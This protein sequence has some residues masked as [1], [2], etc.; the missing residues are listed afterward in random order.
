MFTP[1]FIYA[2]NSRP[3]ERAGVTCYIGLGSNLGRR[4]KNIELALNCLR[5]TGGI[6][7]ERLSS[8]SET[9]PQNCPA[10]SPRFINGVVKIKTVFNP[11]QLLE[12]L[13]T[14]E[15]RLGRDRAREIPCRRPIDL[16]ILFYGDRKIDAPGLKIPHPRLEE[17]DF[18]LKP[19]KEIAPG[20][21]KS[22]AK[23]MKII[24]SIAQMRSF[25]LKESKKHRTIGFVPTMGCL[26]QG[27]L[28]LIRQAK[29]DCHTC[30]VSIFV[31]P[32]Q[33][34]PK[35][36]YRIYPRDLERDSILAK[37]A[38]CDCIFYPQV[39][40]MYPKSYL[41]YVNVEE[42]TDGLCGASRPGHFKGVATVLTKLFNIVQPGIAY[43]GQKDYQQALVIQ[44][45]VKDLNMPLKIKVMP[46]IRESDGLAL[47]SRNA[48]LNIQEREDA[49]I[50]YKS[51]QKAKEMVLGGEED[52]KKIITKLKKYILKKRS[53]RI[54]YV[55][56]VDAE[57]LAPVSQIK[58]RVL[59][60]LA[61][62]IGK[63]R[64]VDNLIIKGA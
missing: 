30:V 60:V 51:L 34:G 45:M 41:T 58:R 27:H 54:E 42:I 43:F 64:L 61:V 50:L 29:K 25:K 32:I 15:K 62:W 21:I 40:N 28:S 38:G 2:K 17:R 12:R 39:K 23:K 33:F 44:N 7:I 16:D 52:T 49:L 24:S 36:D 53:A 48:Y 14:I 10:G 31:N 4:R 8:L 9:E 19:L 47:S 1:P 57:T 37:S 35:E 11:G 26:H 3:L 6:K 55:A 46:I 5:D 20:R 59:V 63:T 13:G 56:L 18:V 22:L